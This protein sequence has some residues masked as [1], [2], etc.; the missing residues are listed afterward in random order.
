MRLVHSLL[1]VPIKAAFLVLALAFAGGSARAQSPIALAVHGPTPDAERC[2]DAAL[3]RDRVAHYGGARSTKAAE[4]RFELELETADA[5]ELRVYRGPALVSVRRFERLPVSCIDR[6]DTIAL[7]MAF[8]LEGATHAV[9]SEA[10]S[11]SPSEP[12]APSTESA[13]QEPAPPRAPV[14][15]QPTEAIAPPSA[16]TSTRALEPVPDAPSDPYTMTIRLLLGGRWLAEALPAPVWVGAL[17][18]ELQLTRGLA[19]DLVALASTLVSRAYAGARSEAQLVGGELL[20]CTHWKFGSFVTQSCLGALAAA[21]PARGVRYP[22]VHSGTLLWAAGAARVALRWPDE[23]LISLRLS[24][25]GH[26]NVVRPE[27]QVTG[28]EQLLAA[29]WLGG[30]VGLDMIITFE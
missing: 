17:G 10:V 3:L 26:V 7:S 6:R 12:D 11:G 14:Q 16:A 4:L 30:S 28:A 22:A 20:G 13:A 5:A 1:D 29:T 21:C 9:E 2:F 15:E 23:Q 19:L 8:A 24:L 27:L 25:Q 18:A